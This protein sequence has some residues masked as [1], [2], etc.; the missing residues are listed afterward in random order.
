MSLEDC[1]N[2]TL[3]HGNR[4]WNAELEQAFH[5]HKDDQGLIER[6]AFIKLA[7]D[8]GVFIKKIPNKSTGEVAVSHATRTSCQ[9]LD[10]SD[11]EDD[12]DVVTAVSVG[13]GVGL[14]ISSSPSELPDCAIS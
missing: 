10:W 13:V 5:S 9:P 1:K 6:K 4:L 7:S 14:A 12:L 8:H 11:E 2:L 3:K